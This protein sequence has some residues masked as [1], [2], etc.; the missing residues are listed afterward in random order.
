MIATQS[1]KFLASEEGLIMVAPPT[2]NQYFVWILSPLWATC[3][4]NKINLV[5]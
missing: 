4:P 3:V 5:A 1:E 2:L